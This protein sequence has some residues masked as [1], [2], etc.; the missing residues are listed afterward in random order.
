MLSSDLKQERGTKSVKE[1]VPILGRGR[2]L[3][4]IPLLGEIYEERHKGGGFLG[5]EPSGQVQ[6]PGAEAGWVCLRARRHMCL[7]PSE[8]RPMTEGQ[9]V[10]MVDSLPPSIPPSVG[11]WSLSLWHR[12]LGGGLPSLRPSPSPLPPCLPRPLL[13]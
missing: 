10:M 3:E 8:L 6:K 11:R 13:S 9:R 5:K 2:G 7:K 4:N 12:R 1:E